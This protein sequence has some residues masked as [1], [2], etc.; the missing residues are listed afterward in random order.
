MQSELGYDNQIKV[1]ILR[2]PAN[3][4]PNTYA[5]DKEKDQGLM[6]VSVTEPLHIVQRHYAPSAGASACKVSAT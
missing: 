5:F 4:T 6:L 2:N 3:S 1:P